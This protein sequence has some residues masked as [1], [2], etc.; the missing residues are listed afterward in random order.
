MKL[1][2]LPKKFV[3]HFIRGYFDGDGNVWSGYI[4]KNR[5]NPTLILN[6]SITSASTDFLQSLKRFLE[7]QGIVGGSL[8][9]IKGKK[10][11]RLQYS[12]LNAL[13]LSKIMYNGSHG[14]FLARKKAVFDKF[15]KMRP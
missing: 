8:Y 10:C 7:E 12:T 5:E 9:D 15:I 14:L 2:E 3:H 6:I 13:K 1:P 4:H 11:S